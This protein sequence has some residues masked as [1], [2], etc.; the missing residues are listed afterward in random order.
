MENRRAGIICDLDY[1]R[2]ISFKNYFYAIEYL[3]HGIK[4]VFTPND[5]DYIDILFVGDDH[6]GKHRNVMTQAGFVDKCN[7]LGIDAVVFTTEKTFG[8][9]FGWNEEG[10]QFLKKFEKLHL[11]MTDVD[12]CIK[13]GTKL[14][15]TVPSKHFA[16]PKQIPKEEKKDEIVFIGSTEG[17]VDCYKHRKEILTETQKLVPLVIIPSNIPTW[18]KYMETLSQYRFIFA[19]RGNC[20]AF[21]L[22]FYDALM[23]YSIPVQEVMP[24]TLKYFDIEAS[25]DDCIFFQQ[26]EEISE[27]IKNCTLKYSH[28]EIWM[29][30]YLQKLLTEDGLL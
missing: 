14:N 20:N 15:R 27:K 30:D 25:F 17:Y 9:I 16:N 24:N 19:P 5:L 8:S 4:M 22:R 29:E 21:S 2:H 3:Y 12:D 1:S 28:N 18:E 7:K 10:F 23:V 6:Y 11:Y 26:P 13:T